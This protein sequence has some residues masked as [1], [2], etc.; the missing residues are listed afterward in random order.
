MSENSLTLNEKAVKK[1]G[2]VPPERLGMSEDFFSMF[3][4]ELEKRGI[5]VTEEE[6][7]R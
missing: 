1:K 5:K 7:S 2:V 3:L 6:I 4:S